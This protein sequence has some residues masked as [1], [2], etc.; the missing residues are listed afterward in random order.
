MRRFLLALALPLLTTFSASSQNTAT[1]PVCIPSVQA[2]RIADSL[3][4]LPLVRREASAWQGSASQ[5]AQSAR[6]Y[7]AADS[8][9]YHAFQQ[10]RGALQDERLLTANETAKMDT[11]RHRA[12]KRGLLNYLLT[13]ALGGSFYLLFKP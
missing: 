4:V 3:A 13:A 12:R 11:W 6:T 9:H 5:F 10:V 8:L 7:R 1:R 2:A